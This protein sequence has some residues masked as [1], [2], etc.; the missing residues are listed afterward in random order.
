MDKELEL[1]Y[2]LPYTKKYDSGGHYYN[3][4]KCCIDYRPASESIWNGEPL[5]FDEKEQL[6]NWFIQNIGEPI[7]TVY[8]IR[9]IAN[10]QGIDDVI[11]ITNL[12]NGKTGY[13]T[14]LNKNSYAW[15]D[16][17]KSESCGKNV[18]DY[19]YTFEFDNK[20]LFRFKYIYEEFSKRGIKIKCNVYKNDI[21]RTNC[22]DFIGDP[23]YRIDREKMKTKQLVLYV[24]HP[25]NFW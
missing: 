25:S 10:Y 6:L 1:F 5:V 9:Y 24:R 7:P 11:K 17:K 23:F 13:Y 12:N 2:I 19:H 8:R 3:D 4:D 21:D 16:A 15:Y 14:A 20:V 18:W 22:F